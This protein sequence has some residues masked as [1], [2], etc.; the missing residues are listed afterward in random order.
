MGSDLQFMVNNSHVQY[1]Q[2]VLNYCLSAKGQI[3]DLPTFQLTTLLMLLLTVCPAVT[4]KICYPCL[5]TNR[6][7]TSQ[8]ELKG[9]CACCCSFCLLA[10]AAAR[11]FGRCD[12]KFPTD[13]V[14]K[15]I[16]SM[17]ASSSS[18]SVYEEGV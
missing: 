10:V 2:D 8:K 6:W 1:A 17:L 13:F 5:P 14:C 18:S 12:S 11:S 15:M 9:Q 4:L 16:R 3:L 7:H